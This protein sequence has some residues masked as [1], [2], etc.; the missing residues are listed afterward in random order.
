M[1]LLEVLALIVCFVVMLA[2]A[3]VCFKLGKKILGFFGSFGVLLLSAGALGLMFHDYFYVKDVKTY[4]ALLAGGLLIFSIAAF[5]E[6][7]LKEVE[8]W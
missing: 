3:I 6:H 7:R 4:V 2:F 5:G 1:S 8:K